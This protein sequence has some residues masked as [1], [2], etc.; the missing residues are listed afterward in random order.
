MKKIV[1]SIAFV[2]AAVMFF[3]V[4]ASAATAGKVV[5][6]TGNLNLR[7]GPSVS[8]GI[9]STAKSGSWLTLEEKSGDWYRVS[10]G[11]DKTAYAKADYIRN[12]TAT[13]EGTVNVTSGVLN[14]RSGPGT[15]YAVKDTLKRGDRILAV[16]SNSTWAGIVYNGNKTGYVAKAY[17]KRLSQNTASYPA[18][19]LSVPSFKQYDALWKDYPIGTQGGT[20]GKIG[21]LTTAIAMVESYAASA[22]VTP[23]QMAKKLSYSVSGS[24][25]WPADYIRISSDESYLSEIYSLLKK[26]K[27]VIV[28]AKTSSG[29]Q[30]WVVVYGYEGADSLSADK[31]LINDPGSEKRLTLQSFLSAYPLKDR[32]VYKK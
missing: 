8:S 23:V 24:L 16:K 1:Y 20:I 13:V 17:L 4:S 12:Y 14:V 21:C 29:G 31:F 11:K 5:T 7:E 9:I 22:T 28:G 15:N 19:K 32:I 30:H 26:G 27:P 18:V 2:F 10:Y 6:T 3:T 25:Y